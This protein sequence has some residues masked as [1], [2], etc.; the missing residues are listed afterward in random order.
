MPD[1]FDIEK[2]SIRDIL[3]AALGDEA[4]K[5]EGKTDDYVEAVLDSV[6]ANRSKAGVPGTLPHVASPGPV[7]VHNAAMGEKPLST[8]ELRNL[9]KQPLN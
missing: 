3:N 4:K 9:A 2:A 8:M 1:G 7:G 6:L 5:Y